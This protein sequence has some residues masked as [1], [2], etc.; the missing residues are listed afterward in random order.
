MS[1]IDKVPKPQSSLDG[2]KLGEH[3]TQENKMVEN[4]EYSNY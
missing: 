1:S 4:I 3:Q 2:C